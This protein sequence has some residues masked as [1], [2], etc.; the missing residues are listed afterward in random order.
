MLAANLRLMTKVDLL[1][2]CQQ[3]GVSET[4]L[5]ADLVRRL[6]GKTIAPPANPNPAAPNPPAQIKTPDVHLEWL[7][8]AGAYRGMCYS[9]VPLIWGDRR[10][11]F[12]PFIWVVMLVQRPLDSAEFRDGDGLPRAMCC[13]LQRLYKEYLEI[14][15]AECAGILDDMTDINARLR[16]WTP[17]STQT[18]VNFF[19]ENGARLQSTHSRLVEY[20]LRSVNP[21]AAQQVRLRLPF[22]DV[23]R[24]AVGVGEQLQKA[25]F[26]AEGPKREVNAK[27][28]REERAR[29]CAHCK[30]KVEGSYQEHNKICNKKKK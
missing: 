29:T 23:T 26:F 5:K 7:T 22:G 17:S 27:R 4:G 6:T 3:C 20:Q 28:G 25:R 8:S 13:R 18:A 10:V 14:N 9:S 1:L 21:A 2:L 11:L 19:F 12:D 24:W 16:G 30:L 15:D